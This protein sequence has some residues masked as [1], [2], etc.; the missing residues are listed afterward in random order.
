MDILIKRML[1]RAEIIFQ[2]SELDANISKIECVK[3]R[4]V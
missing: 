1:N 2:G 3:K 4:G